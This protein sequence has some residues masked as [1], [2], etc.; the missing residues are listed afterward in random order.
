LNK[1]SQDKL[2]DS[3]REIA[4]AQAQLAE[5]N[6][7]DASRIKRLEVLT[8]SRI[9]AE[10]KLGDEIKKQ[11]A[12]NSQADESAESRAQ[13]EARL[14][15][16]LDKVRIEIR[17]LDLERKKA[18]ATETLTEE[19]LEG[20]ISRYGQ[21]EQRLKSLRNEFT[22]SSR[23]T[24]QI[25]TAQSQLF[26]ATQR[27]QNGFTSLSGSIA[28]ST[29]LQS[30]ANQT[31]IEF[32]R[33]LSDAQQF[34]FGLQSGIIAVGNNISQ[35]TEVGGRFVKSAGGIRGA[36]T[37]IAASL[38]GVGGVILAVNAL[39]FALPFLGKAFSKNKE[40]VEGTNQALQDYNSILDK[41]R[42]SSSSDFLGLENKRLAIQEDKELL[43]VL[44]EIDV[45]LKEQEKLGADIIGRKLNTQGQADISDLEIKL[46][47]VNKQLEDYR[48]EYRAIAD[49]PFDEIDAKI[50]QTT[51]SIDSQEI[52]LRKFANGVGAAYEDVQNILEEFQ[53]SVDSTGKELTAPINQFVELQR[54]S[55]GFVKQ[56]SDDGVLNQAER[57]FLSWLDRIVK[58]AKD[59][60]DTLETVVEEP[61]SELFGLLTDSDIDRII[62]EVD[63]L[64]KPIQE[65][66]NI[67]QDIRNSIKKQSALIDISILQD[68]FDDASK[69]IQDRY[70]LELDLIEGTVVGVEQ[71]ETAKLNALKNRLRAEEALLRGQSGT[72]PQIESARRLT[73]E[74]AIIQAGNFNEA[75]K[76]IDDETN[77][78]VKAAERTIK[79]KA[80]REA[81]IR[82]IEAEGIRDK[83]NIE[84]AKLDVV[85]RFGEL[86]VSAISD[87][88]D[89]ATQLGLFSAK[90][91]FN[92]QKALGVSQATI[93]AYRTISSIWADP[94]LPTTAKIGLS[95]AQGAAAFARVAKIASTK[96]GQSGSNSE[97]SA[98]A[99]SFSEGFSFSDIQPTT[100]V[101][102]V[103][104]DSFVDVLRNSQSSQN[105]VIENRVSNKE[106]YTLVKSGEGEVLASSQSASR[107]RFA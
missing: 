96:F 103:E 65:I 45:L 64:T 19:A 97:A 53:S 94:L 7:N 83:A 68:N 24:R 51:E 106:F 9:T 74:L 49:I 75:K 89:A 27:A 70:Q 80:V 84:S 85:Q 77:L 36:F 17:D 44:R 63:A 43:V 98:S 52:T 31:V 14:R 3:Y 90:R 66:P 56:F 37:Q 11:I 78:R 5:A 92:I 20:T 79:D 100:P 82:R 28:N 8:T 57:S 13:A 29:K 46:S 105:I 87:F 39:A 61:V 107:D 4:Q 33:G 6:E 42:G 40:D 32:S 23:G 18:L 73:A 67:F 88:S 69:A 26:N 54:V 59:R 104:A 95:A 71:V 99:S 102:N 10:K 58:G 55:N 38:T 16:E 22:N 21:L 60:V 2:A 86:G 93:D 91:T 34:A 15:A 81:E 101:V 48:K 35:L 25:S 62:K 41:V 47:L 72:N 30:Q 76:L 50:K 12:A 1:Q